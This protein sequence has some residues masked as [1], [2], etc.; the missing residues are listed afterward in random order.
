MLDSSLFRMVS[1]GTVVADKNKN[2]QF[3]SVYL[4][5][6]LPFHTG[7]VTDDVVDIVR[8]GVDMDGIAYNVVL[9]RCLTVKARWRGEPNRLTSPC[10]KNG[11]D[12][13]IWE[14]GN[15]GIYY[16]SEI[17]GTDHLK[18]TETVTYGWNASGT[19]VE[20][21]EASTANNKYTATV[22]TEKGFAE[23][24]TTMANGEVASYAFQMN[25]KD[26][27]A[28]LTDHL[29]NVFQIS[30][31]DHG[32]SFTNP[33]KTTIAAHGKN[34]VVECEGTA[35][36]KCKKATVEYTE[37]AYVG[38]AGGNGITLTKDKMVCKFPKMVF[39]GDVEVIG[40]T[41]VTVIDGNVANIP[42]LHGV[43]DSARN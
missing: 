17:P 43:A 26:G 21:N 18:R 7:N 42:T 30:S 11:Q 3:L 19:P 28:T 4:K 2:S 33:D 31:E 16:W 23:F 34:A 13:E 12:V 24:K 8:S 39:D 37:E 20:E 10:L 1:I 25:G 15:T 36:I 6:K 32:I 5:E 35:K 14:A 41:K 22:D 9:Q 29:G 38:V 27:H 40:K